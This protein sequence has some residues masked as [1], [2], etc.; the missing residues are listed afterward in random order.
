M[1]F[2]A[3]TGKCESPVKTFKLRKKISLSVKERIP[4]PKPTKVSIVI[5]EV[6]VQ[7]WDPNTEGDRPH[8]PFNN[9][10]TAVEIHATFYSTIILPEGYFPRPPSLSFLSDDGSPTWEGKCR[11]F[12]LSKEDRAKARY[13]PLEGPRSSA[14]YYHRV[15][16][17]SGTRRLVLVIGG[18]FE[19]HP[20]YLLIDIE[21][22]K[23]KFCFTEKPPYNP[24]KIKPGLPPPAEPTALWTFP[25][26]DQMD[27]PLPSDSYPDGL[28]IPF[29]AAP[30][31]TTF[32]ERWNPARIQCLDGE[33]G[34]VRWEYPLPGRLDN[35]GR[36]LEGRYDSDTLKFVTGIGDILIKEGF[37]SLVCLYN[38]NGTR[39]WEVKAEPSEF[40][41]FE[42]DGLLLFGDEG[43]VIA[44]SAQ[45]GTE[46]WRW[47]W[48]IEKHGELQIGPAI[49]LGI[50]NQMALV[51]THSD[52]GQDNSGN[53]QFIL[54]MLRATDGTVIWQKEILDNYCMV[55]WFSN[56][57]LFIHNAN[58]PFI[59]EL[60]PNTGK[61][62]WSNPRPENVGSAKL[63]W[64]D[65]LGNLYFDHQVPSH[66]HAR[67]PGEKDCECWKLNFSKYIDGKTLRSIDKIPDNVEVQY[68]NDHLLSDNGVVNLS[69]GKG[70][71][72]RND[73]G[74]ISRF[75]TELIRKVPTRFDNVLRRVRLTNGF[76]CICLRR[77][78]S[79]AGRDD[80]R[81]I[82]L[83][84]RPV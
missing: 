56:K 39:K 1:I 83:G 43:E 2:M 19:K 47:R 3:S 78:G 22:G 52:Y 71:I 72:Q 70:R 18:S 59:Q 75:P 6:K 62:L 28:A 50:Y 37:R 80:T 58:E 38:E 10:V 26:A 73:T 57:R 33:T 5:E 25:T 61:M 7:Q 24:K 9:P 14:D 82:F 35:F 65:C 60:D 51:G 40:A 84:V 8:F 66:V 32:V 27:P 54:T 15:Y 81:W 13:G 34:R 12:P 46:I 21:T 77:R 55:R 45:T 11:L 23:T 76:A 31:G 67:L 64:F 63:Q 53:G 49:G 36:P 69:P 17:Q 48:G 41:N 44:L 74:S 16:V 30:N 42:I 4:K 29:M 20:P 68:I 79:W